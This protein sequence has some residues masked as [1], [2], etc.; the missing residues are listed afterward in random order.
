MWEGES[1]GCSL[2]FVVSGL[3]SLVSGE[4]G[5]N[6]KIGGFARTGLKGIVVEDGAGFCWRKQGFHPW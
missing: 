1:G 2:W 3:K 6:G 5:E 4:V